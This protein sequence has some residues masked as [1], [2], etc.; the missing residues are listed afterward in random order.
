VLV[1]E[2]DLPE[3]QARELREALIHSISTYEMPKD[4][5]VS[6]AFIYTDTNKINRLESFISSRPSAH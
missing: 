5:F 1:L 6:S 2:S 4:F 3:H